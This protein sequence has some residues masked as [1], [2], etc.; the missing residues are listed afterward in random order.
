[1]PL[2]MAATALLAAVIF[3][4]DTL[5]DVYGAIAVLYVVVLLLA[6]P[7]LSRRGIVSLA[8]G[9]VLLTALSLLTSHSWPIDASAWLRFLTALAAIAVTT[10][11]LLK[12]HASRQRLVDANRALATSETRYR[13][14]FEQAQFSLWEQDF[15]ALHEAMIALRREGVDD[16][17][18]HAA[19]RPDFARHCARLIRTTA[20]NA[21]T[22]DLLGLRSTADALGTLE[23]F[24]PEDD[25][26]LAEVATALLRGQRRLEGKGS[27]LRADGS[28]LTVLF[29]IQFPAD[30]AALDRVVVGIVD[31]TQREAMQEALIAAQAE[32]AR[33]SRAATVGALSASIAHE[34]NQPLGALVMNAQ[35]CLRWLRREPPDIGAAAKAAERIAREGRRASEIVQKTRRM[36][37]K[38]ARQP[39]PIDMRQ[40]VREAGALLERELAARSARLVTEFDQDVPPVLTDAVEMQQVLINLMTNGLQAMADVEPQR[41]LLTVRVD[42]PDDEQVRVTVRD[43]GGGIAEADLPNLFTPFFSTKADGMGMGLAICRTIVEANGGELS[44]GNHAEGGALLTFTLPSAARLSAPAPEDS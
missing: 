12:E 11:L 24:I 41:R 29:G 16:L 26:T 20:V 9:C 13:L 5:V 6:A 1:M 18:A 15:S 40:L 36:L 4:I 2:R 21:A 44:A 19:E 14:L 27:L 34:V 38:G 3:T 31:I 23:R 28:R 7:A 30:A 22:A 43:R 42:R 25:T 10:M 8:A 37:V 33:A 35:T 32:L 39:V 17:A